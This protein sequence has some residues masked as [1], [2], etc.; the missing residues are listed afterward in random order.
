MSN[1]LQWRHDRP[2]KLTRSLRWN[3]N[4]WAGWNFDGDNL[5]SGGNFNA[6]AVFV[7][8]WSAGFGINADGQGFDDRATRGGPGAYR[9]AGRSLWTY[10]NSDS[11]K[12]LLFYVNT[13]N[14]TRN[15]GGGSRD[16]SPGVNLRPATFVRISAGLRMTVNED[17]QQWIGNDDGHYV[18]GRI[19]QQTV[20]L[21]ARFN[22]TV[23]PTLTVQ[24]YAE[25]F[26]S[27]GSYSEFQELVDGRAK[28]FGARFTPYAYG[29]SPDF[30]YRSFRTI[31]VLRWEYRPGSTLF[32]VWQ[33]GR[34]DVVESG[35]FD[36]GRDFRGAFDAPGR[37]VFLVKWAYWLNY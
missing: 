15:E 21:T 4:Q 1:W 7:N 23:T 32:V 24:M 26:V 25:P 30:N 37:N 18:F 35:R 22:Y 8:H 28:Q 34:E 10:A 36:F 27:A 6:D 17:P 16:V 20:G 11:R 2:T 3:L 5:Y 9:S 31:N 19:E 29:G 13:F 33:Q 14:A 12:R